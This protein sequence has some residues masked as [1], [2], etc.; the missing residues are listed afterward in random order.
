MSKLTNNTFRML[1]LIQVVLC[2]GPWVSVIL[3]NLIVGSGI[4]ENFY[5][6][7]VLF[8]FSPL[9]GLVIGVI[10]F[11]RSSVSQKGRWLSFSLSFIVIFLLWA[12]I[13][14]MFQLVHRMSPLGVTM[15]MKKLIAC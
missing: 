3:S 8:F 9:L 14:T 2:L 12:F 11:F 13:S 5:V 6:N 10:A 1:F 4:T 7:I 15:P